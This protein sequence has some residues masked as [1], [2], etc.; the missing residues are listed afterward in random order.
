[1]V[2]FEERGSHLVTANFLLWQQVNGSSLAKGVAC[3]T[4]ITPGQKGLGSSS[5]SLH[6]GSS[7]TPDLDGV[8]KGGLEQTVIHPI[9]IPRPIGGV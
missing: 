5:R 1:M 3:E 6:G 2:I 7:H 9:A 4:M 8:R